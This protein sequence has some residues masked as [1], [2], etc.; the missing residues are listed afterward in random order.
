MNWNSSVWNFTQS[1]WRKYYLVDVFSIRVFFHKHWRFT[2]QKGKR[3]GPRFI[4][5]YHF[6]RL[7]KFEILLWNFACG[8]TATYF[9]SRSFVSTRLLLNG[10]CN[11]L[12]YYLTDQWCN[13]IFCLFTWWF[14]S[15][16]LLQKFDT[17]N[18][19]IWIHIVHHLCITNESINQKR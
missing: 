19:W 5:L 14:D 16:F 3:R 4:N 10:V 8:M 17:G 2:G 12:N 1:Q 11:L 7:A 9:L 18:C 15:R 6:H 13:V